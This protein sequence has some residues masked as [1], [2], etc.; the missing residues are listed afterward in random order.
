MNVCKSKPQ[1]FIIIGHLVCVCVYARVYLCVYVCVCVCE[2]ER[3][4]VCVSVQVYVCVCKRNAKKLIIIGHLE[5]V[6]T[7][8]CAWEREC[9]CVC[10]SMCEC[11][12][13]HA[14]EYKHTEEFII[15]GHLLSAPSN[16]NL[17]LRFAK[18]KRK[19]Y[20]SFKKK[21]ALEYWKKKTALGLLHN[22]PVISTFMLVEPKPQSQKPKW[23]DF[24]IHE[25]MANVPPA[26]KQTT[27]KTNFM[28]ITK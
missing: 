8:E 16:L 28:K 7:C 20:F 21:T 27:L 4:S 25:T 22:Q 26:I 11:L 2:R 24:P 3:A 1:Q 5:C 15:V 18:Q 19:V 14:C 9:A 17:Y 10:M 13:V 6:H 23:I 12:C